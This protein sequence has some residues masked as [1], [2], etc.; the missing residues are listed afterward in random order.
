MRTLI[1]LAL[2]LWVAVAQ[3][4]AVVVTVNGK[5][6]LFDQ[7]QPI[8]RGGR[9]LV[10]LRGVFEMLGARV[11]YEPSAQT[12]V[13]RR[14]EDVIRLKIGDDYAL[15]N[16]ETVIMKSRAILRDGTALVPLRFLAETL[17]ADVVWDGAKR[18]VRISTTAEIDVQDEKDGKVEDPPDPR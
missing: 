5:R 9:V 18:M 13:V 10:P 6:V 11:G 4:P 3:P 2:A 16:N 12:V 7:A 8:E 17:E 15:K 1:A 14:G